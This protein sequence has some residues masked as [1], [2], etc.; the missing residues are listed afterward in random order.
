MAALTLLDLPSEIRSA[1]LRHIF[2]SRVILFL[3]PKAYNHD[4]YKNMHHSWFL[5]FLA[6]NRQLH[7]EGHS[8][9]RSAV[10]LATLILDGVVPE[11]RADHKEIDT[12]LHVCRLLDSF[13]C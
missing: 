13:I 5:N 11:T 6:V 10:S 12:H 2:S 9:L 7:D 8:A 4:Y 3:V 1:T